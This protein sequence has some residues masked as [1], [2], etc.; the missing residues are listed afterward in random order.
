[1][2]LQ[3]HRPLREVTLVVLTALLP[4]MFRGTRMLQDIRVADRQMVLLGTPQVPEEALPPAMFLVTRMLRVIKATLAAHPPQIIQEAHL[5][6][7]GWGLDHIAVLI[8]DQLAQVRPRQQLIVQLSAVIHPTTPTPLQ[9]L[10]LEK[11][12]KQSLEATSPVNQVAKVRL[13]QEDTQVGHAG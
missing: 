8:L 10:Y 7:P 2:V 9:T 3:L 1:M 5:P 11:I 13:E 6:V 4:A 12:S